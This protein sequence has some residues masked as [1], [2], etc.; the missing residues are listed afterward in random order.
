MDP[1]LEHNSIFVTNCAK[2]CTEI[3]KQTLKDNKVDPSWNDNIALNTAIIRNKPEIVKLL[4][5]DKR[6]L[7]YSFY[8]EEHYFNYLILHFTEKLKLSKINV[9]KIYKLM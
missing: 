6:F 2:G 3:V 8:L 7:K 5:N 4:L 9:L 1:I